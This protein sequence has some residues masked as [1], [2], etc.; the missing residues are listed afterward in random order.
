MTIKTVKDI[1]GDIVKIDESTQKLYQFSNKNRELIY[2]AEI[3]ENGSR[4]G[5]YT[6]YKEEGI[7]DNIEEK[8]NTF[9]NKLA[10]QYAIAVDFNKN[11]NDPKQEKWNKFIKYVKENE[12]DFFDKHGDFKKK[13]MVNLEEILK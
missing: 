8:I 3:I 12:N 9:G 5:F 13:I 11:E 1:H 2:N 6:D 4:T 10:L 7:C